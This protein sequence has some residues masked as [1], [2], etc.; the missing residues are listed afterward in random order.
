MTGFKRAGTRLLA[1]FLVAT[2]TSL[3]GC[4][5]IDQAMQG[6]TEA[7]AQPPAGATAQAFPPE[8]GP[9]PPAE[10]GATP[11]PAPEGAAPVAVAPTAPV[12]ATTVAPPPTARM[13][14]ISVQPGA[15]TGTAVGRTVSGLRSQLQAGAGQ[16]SGDAQRLADLKSSSAQAIATYQQ[17][18]AN[19]QTRLAVGTAPGNPELIGQWNTAQGA[20]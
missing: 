7:A 16:V 18:T 10:V 6:G 8:A 12:T 2:A 9:P 14:P 11:A 4:S 17:A 19:I 13:A 20:L 15:D 1:L 5:S 3:A